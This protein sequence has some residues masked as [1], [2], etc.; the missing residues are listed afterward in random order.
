MK[1]CICLVCAL[2]LLLTFLVAC[3]GTAATEYEYV[4]YGYGSSDCFYHS[5][6]GYHYAG[7]PTGEMN[8][9]G[10]F[11]RTQR[12][13]N[14]DET[15]EITVQQV[16]HTANWWY[17]SRYEDG[18][19][20]DAYRIFS[21]D[22]VI[23]QFVL[24]NGALQTF[25]LLDVEPQI[26]AAKTEEECIRIAKEEIAAHF[27]FDESV[28]RPMVTHHVQDGYITVYFTR[29]ELFPEGIEG[30]HF[31]LADSYYVTMTVDG[32]VAAI[33]TDKTE[34]SNQFPADTQVPIDLAA[35]QAAVDNA[36][37]AFEE[38]ASLSYE[39]VIYVCYDQRMESHGFLPYFAVC[40]IHYE[41]EG[42]WQEQS[43]AVLIK[44]VTKA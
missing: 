39:T 7:L 43:Y 23:G 6:Y 4:A 26:E 13:A 25:A 17:S 1:R 9:I 16:R 19:K 44:P 28:Y 2:A 33:G 34:K 8:G 11:Y 29:P 12:P 20:E 10:V 35:C 21:G 14:T 42:E 40:R 22:Q 18:K 32:T 5:L 27:Q 15:V 31:V 41:V 36:V 3:N 37:R 24:V 38:G 30:R